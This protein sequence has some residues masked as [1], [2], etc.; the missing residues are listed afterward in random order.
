MTTVSTLRTD[1]LAFIGEHK[2]LTL[3]E[4]RTDYGALVDMPDEA[5]EMAEQI[6]GSG[7]GINDRMKAFIRVSEQVV[8]MAEGGGDS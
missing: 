6:A 5:F 1:M 4:A 2:G 7:A 8:K 3:A